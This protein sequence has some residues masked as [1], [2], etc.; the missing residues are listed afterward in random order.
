MTT[1]A[2]TGHTDLTGH[3]VGLV[4]SSLSELLL[5]Y[6]DET[7]DAVSCL[8]EGADSLFAEAALAA[9]ARLVAV[10][11]SEK[12]WTRPLP[13]YWSAP[14]GRPRCGTGPA[15]AEGWR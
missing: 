14:T 9:N 4:R 2:V 1:L 11:P 6:A 8:A 10:I 13:F 7:L 12:P 3:T 15:R 5:H